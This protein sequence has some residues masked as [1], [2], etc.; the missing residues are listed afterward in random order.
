MPSTSRLKSSDSLAQW[1]QK[2]NQLADQVDVIS[3]TSGSIGGSGYTSGQ[4]AAYGTS[5][6]N[7][8]PG[9]DLSSAISGG[10]INF[11]LTPAAFTNKTAITSVDAANDFLLIYQNSS[12]L[13]K[14]VNPQYIATPGGSTTFVQFN[15]AGAFGGATGFTFSAGV[16]TVPT[17][18]TINTNNLYV[19]GG[20]VGIG[21]VIPAQPL[22]VTGNIAT[23]TA[24]YVGGNSVLSATTLGASVVNSGLTSVGTL[25]TLAVTGAGVFNS[26]LASASLS[27]TGSVTVGTTLSVTGSVGIGTASPTQK[28]VVAGAD[29]VNPIWVR[30]NN[31]SG[32][33]AG[34]LVSNSV[35]TDT[36]ILYYDNNN[37]RIIVGSITNVPLGF[38]TNNTERMRIDTSGNVGIGTSSPLVKLE[39]TGS[40]RAS[41][42]ITIGTSGTYQ[43][44]SI[45][46]NASWGMI[47]RAATA[48]PTQAEFRWANSIDTEFMRINSTGNVGI[49]TTSIT[50]RLT[51]A[52]AGNQ[53]DLN[54]T[55][56]AAAM[57]LQAAGVNK[58]QIY[59][60]AAN[61][62][63][64]Y[65]YTAAATRLLINT[66]GNVG[67]SATL[68]VA[69]TCNVTGV[70]T[71]RTSVTLQST[72]LN[73]VVAQTTYIVTATGIT[74]TLPA[75]PTTGDMI[76]F[77]PASSSINSY[78]VARN[79]NT[80]MGLSSDLTVD[81]AA[82]FDLVY[83]G[84]GWVLA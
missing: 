49:G 65:D 4:I 16:L 79:G 58:W 40:V 81:S 66:S 68:T 46:S 64:I 37:A 29:A 77:R 56:G 60:D 82:P 71:G 12:G 7:Y 78:T 6:I 57:S 23:S 67:I 83:T 15:N 39:V 31:S 48:S 70:L 50:S 17:G 13:V 10:N 18:L 47:F 19:A 26:S 74:L 5:W 14:K 75:S 54:A 69:G 27:V 80:I 20:K 59:N 22:D 32:G 2:T 28:L 53:L 30:V 51:V 73:P 38:N 35:G 72:S 61:Q 33:G 55:S 62:F 25:S 3:S 41:E 84:S 1:A 76:G 21:N 45:F 36:G 11:T 44:G 52:G 34:F 43:A 9:A 24:Y 63:G 8:T 42:S